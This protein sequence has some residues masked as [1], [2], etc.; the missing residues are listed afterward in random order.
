[1]VNHHP[2]R[3]TRAQLATLAGM[4]VSG[5]T[6]GTYL[7]TLRRRGLLLERDRLL[8]VT[9]DGLA[10]AG[11]RPGDAPLSATDVREQWRAA[12][13]A[14]ARRMFDVVVDA[15]PHSVT[16]VALAS[17]V[18]IELTGGT[19]GTYLSTL[20]R[21]GLVE[22]SGDTVRAAEVLFLTP[23]AATSR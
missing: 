21:N 22:V 23:A 10:A 4:K 8:E 2:M 6:Y 11:A 14:G 1:M 19:F 13:K 3:L 9:D 12:L 16:R 18:D 7:S 17:E 20:R 15:Y 5:G